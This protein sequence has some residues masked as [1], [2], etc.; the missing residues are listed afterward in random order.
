MSSLPSA[1]LLADRRALRRKLSL[2]RLFALGIAA[3]AILGAGLALSGSRWRPLDRH[4]AKIAISGVITGDEES[5]KLIRSVANAKS[6]AAAMIVI[7]SPGG[8]TAGA[9]R[10]HDEIRRLAE[11]KPVVAVVGTLAASGGYIAA[12][13]ADAIV[14][15]GNSLVGSIGVLFQ[16]PNVSRLLEM[17]GVKM[18]DVKSSPLKASPNPFEP[19]NEPAR[20]AIAAL[21]A[22][23]FDWFKTLVKTR[24]SLDDAEL[25]RVAD[26]RV[27]TGRQAVGLKLIDRLGGEREARAWLDSEKKI[28]TTLPL[29]EWKPDRGLERFGLTTIVGIA[30]DWAGMPGLGGALRRAAA[31]AELDGLLAIWQGP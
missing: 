14:A 4:V 20:Q 12:I 26:G 7:N 6:A 13:G 29:R 21:V 30:A 18:E 9:E 22:D 15:E 31:P 17:V 23:S 19:T 24:R 25:A 3:L 8:T 1:D 27:F 16:Y 2:W 11:K 5:L 10:L 28:A